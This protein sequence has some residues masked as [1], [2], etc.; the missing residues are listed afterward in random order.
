M[1]QFLK[2]KF[3]ID[4]TTT[5]N[6][7]ELWSVESKDVFEILSELKNLPEY[8]FDMLLNYTVVDKIDDNIFEV[9]YQIFSV[10]LNRCLLIKVSVSRENPEIVSISNLYKS[11]TFD[12]REMYDLFG[13]N[14]IGHENIRRILLPNDWIGH[15]LRKDY[16]LQ[17]E[18]LQWNAR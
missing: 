11:A 18:R 3:N 9:F 7:T 12:E 14:F 13:V 17:D 8:S 6:N 16:K 2:D 1:F 4:I 10:S 15:H 5:K